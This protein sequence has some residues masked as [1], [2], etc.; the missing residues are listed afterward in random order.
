MSPTDAHRT[1]CENRALRYVAAAGFAYEAVALVT[2]AAPTISTCCRRRPVRV[3]TVAAVLVAHLAT[4]PDK[5]S[6]L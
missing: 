5:R 2:G 1:L 4:L 3:A 6:I